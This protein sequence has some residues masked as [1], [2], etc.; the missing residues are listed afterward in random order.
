[1][2]LLTFYLYHLKKDKYFQYFVNKQLIS[3]LG[4]TATF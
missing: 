1:M 2:C 4:Q 3:T